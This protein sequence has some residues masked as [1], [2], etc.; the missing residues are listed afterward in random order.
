M[1]T[2]ISRQTQHTRLVPRFGLKTF[3]VVVTLLAVW[4]GIQTTKAKRQRA[5][6][7]RI[8]A[9][10]GSVRFAY[11]HDASGEFDGNA[12]PNGAKWLRTVLG[13]EYFDRVVYIYLAYSDV[14]DDDLSVIAA[15]GDV[16]TF[17]LDGTSIS[18]EGARHLAKQ[19]NIERLF[20]SGTKIGDDGL[21]YL[22]SL[23]QLKGVTLDDTRIT[24]KG[25]A[26]L[27]RHRELVSLNVSGTQI[28]GE[29]LQEIH[30]L[31]KLEYID[32]KR[33]RISNSCLTVLGPMTTAWWLDVC[34]TDVSDEGIAHLIQVASLRKIE[35]DE[36]QV[37]PETL[38]QLRRELPNGR[39]VVHHPTTWPSQSFWPIHDESGITKR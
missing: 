5:A 20:L 36:V 11:Q 24:D 33:T 14:T 23:T 1:G 38:D 12:K 10:G 34:D 26:N 4:F 39:V 25:L 8:A 30:D 7:D 15:L 35:I 27:S 29:G 13:D 3:L 2:M 19:K 18:D 21:K 17:W 9:L 31:P 28:T 22:R 6:M 37:S 32:L 16:K